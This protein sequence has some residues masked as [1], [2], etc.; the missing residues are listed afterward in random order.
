LFFQQRVTVWGYFFLDIISL[1]HVIIYAM[2][3]ALIIFRRSLSD[4]VSQVINLWGYALNYSNHFRKSTLLSM[5]MVSFN[6]VATIFSLC[7]IRK[8]SSLS[9][10]TLSLF[11][12]S[13]IFSYLELY[14]GP[15]ESLQINSF[16]CRCNSTADHALDLLLCSLSLQLPIDIFIDAITRH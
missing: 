13:L 16:P 15:I 1:L 12:P 14:F 10:I 5:A 11:A 8:A 4:S 3:C 6:A 9:S 7:F 2:V